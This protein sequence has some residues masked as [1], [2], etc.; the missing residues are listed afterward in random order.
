M[1]DDGSRGH[2]LSQCASGSSFGWCWFSQCASDDASG[3]SPPRPE[4]PQRRDRAG[5]S[6]PL[7][8]GRALS[9][10]RSRAVESGS[11]LRRSRPHTRGLGSPSGALPR[12]TAPSLSASSKTDNPRTRG[13]ERAPAAAAIP[14]GMRSPAP[15]LLVT[16]L[17]DLR[18]HLEALARAELPD[19]WLAAGAIRNRVWSHLLGESGPPERDW[20]VAFAGDVG[21]DQAEVRLAAQL[22]GPWEAVDQRDFGHRTAAEGIASWPETATAIGARLTARGVEIV[23]PWGL[24]DLLAGRIRRRTA[25]HRRGRVRAP[26]GE[27]AMVA[28]LAG[29]GPSGVGRQ[30]TRLHPASRR[31]RLSNSDRRRWRGGVVAAELSSV[32]HGN[33]GSSGLR[34]HRAEL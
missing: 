32:V 9:G 5:W 8:P 26:P 33:R 27:E 19:A 24:D 25:L 14:P 17:R 4:R 13:T 34:R 30:Q 16:V 3:A 31:A 15:S 6:N 1:S 2:W 7:R 12:R 28:A 29:P 21:S 22:A 20:D 23:A 18:P 10:S 11:R